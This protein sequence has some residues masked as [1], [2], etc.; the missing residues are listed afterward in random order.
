MMLFFGLMACTL[1]PIT[2]ISLLLWFD[3]WRH[4]HRSPCGNPF[5]EAR[6]F[7]WREVFMG[8]NL[9]KHEFEMVQQCK[10]CGRIIGRS[11]KEHHH[12]K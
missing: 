5:I 12:G 6:E 8:D 2:I 10:H 11:T 9:A 4:S 1:T 3:Y 7:G